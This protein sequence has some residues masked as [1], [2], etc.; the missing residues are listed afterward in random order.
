MARKLVQGIHSTN[1]IA[2]CGVALIQKYNRLVMQDEEQ[3]QFLMQI[4][5]E[6]RR[7]FP[8]TEKSTLL[9]GQQ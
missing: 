1:D 9:T 3:L 6:H 8:V 5:T 4:V 2:E 7:A